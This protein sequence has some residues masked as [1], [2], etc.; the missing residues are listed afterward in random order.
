MLPIEE[1]KKSNVDFSD[2]RKTTI[3]RSSL[4]AK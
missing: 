4:T 1:T 3:V 2:E